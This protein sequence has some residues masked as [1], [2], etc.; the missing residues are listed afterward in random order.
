MG[1]KKGAAGDSC[2]RL[3]TKKISC[4]FLGD[5]RLLFYFRRS[6]LSKLT[7]VIHK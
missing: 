6:S 1:I 4:Y 7:E 3:V 5:G 2:P